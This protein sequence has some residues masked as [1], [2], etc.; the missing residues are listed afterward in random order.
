M[1]PL[2]RDDSGV[3]EF[4]LVPWVGACIHTPPPPPNQMV[5]VAVPEGVGDKGRFAAVW[6][7]GE[8]RLRPDSYELFLIDGTRE[9]NV[10]YTMT[11]DRISDY[12]SQESDV[13][14]RVEVPDDLGA[15]HSW[16]QRLRIGSELLFTKTMTDIRDSRSSRAMLWGLLVAFLYG[17]LHTLGPGHGKAVVIAYFIGERGSLWR[18]VRM[19]GQIA[20]LHVLSAIFVVVVTDFAVRQATGRAPSDYRLVRLVSYAAII[21][22]GL[23]MLFKAVRGARAARGVGDHHEH[24]AGCGCAHLAEPA[25]GVAGFLSLAVGAVPCTGALLVLL[26][27]MANDLLWPSVILVVAI[28][29]GMAIALSGVGVAAILGRRY[30]GPQGGGRCPPASTASQP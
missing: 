13:L 26:F 25:E 2:V 7:E 6:I 19:G 24:H 3:A 20:L 28:S 5:H 11:T 22:I 23:W 18:G 21:A 4:L 29:L 14:A 8:I 10:A 1:L 12:S 17:V 16:L 9:I 15:G 30:I 27:G